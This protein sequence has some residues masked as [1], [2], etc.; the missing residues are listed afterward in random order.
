LSQPHEKTTGVQWYTVSVSS[1]RRVITLLMIVSGLI[2]GFLLL[3]RWQHRTLRERAEAT[4]AEARD[5]TRRAERRSDYEQIRIEHFAAWENLEVAR[6]ELAAEHYRTALERAQRGLEELQEV[7]QIAHGPQEGKSRFV[8]VQG[9][10]EYRRGERG[11]WRRARSRDSLNPG[12]WVKTSSDG[13]AEIR[14]PD[15]SKYVLRR[16]TM[17]RLDLSRNLLT[18]SEEQVTDIAFGWIDINTSRRSNKVKTPHAEANVRRDSKAEVEFNPDQ[19][20]GRLAMFEGSGEIVAPSGQ[21][22]QLRALQ[23][24]EQVGDL[25]SQPKPL[26][27]QPRPMRPANDQ[28]VDLSQGALVLAWSAVSGAYRY[29][30]Q[31]S[32]SPLFEPKIISDDN[33][34]KTS[35][36][37]GLQGEGIFYWQ[38]AAFDREGA[39][40]PWS[41]PRAFRV[42]ALQRADDADDRIPPELEIAD[43]QAYGSLVIVNGRTEPGAT[44]TINKEPVSVQV[45]GSFS[46]TIQMSEAGFAFIH[47]V[48]TDAWSNPTEVKRRVFVDAF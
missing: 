2:G 34:R 46:K 13:T 37:L 22:R 40:G 42:A 44:V 5:L 29:A 9:G 28:E 19:G 31:I 20:S 7:L 39:R 43:M 26:P 16:N 18:G 1:F 3:Q 36:K 12:D 24:V 27:G 8:S 17:V 45:D 48:A 33:R 6:E 14:L 41:E 23:Q 25:L 21:T 10:V 30:L 15:G 38:V 35:A 47:I 4:I 11:A 32:R